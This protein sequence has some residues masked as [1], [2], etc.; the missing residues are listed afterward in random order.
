ML[1]LEHFSS[2]IILFAWLSFYLIFSLLLNHFLV[3]DFKA[4]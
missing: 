4:V 2:A 3:E 1:F